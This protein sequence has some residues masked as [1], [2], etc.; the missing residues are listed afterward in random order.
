AKLGQHGHDRGAKV[1]AWGFGDL[2]FE[3]VVGPLFQA[4]VEAADLAVALKVQVVG[5]SSLGAGH[6]TL[7][8]ALVAALRERGAE[9]VV[10]VV[11]GVIPR[12]DYDFLLEH[13]VAA[14]F[15]PGT[16]VLDAAS[17]VLDIVEGRRRNR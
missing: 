15:G 16:N 8:R 9:N 10:V 2:C 14:V 7:A 12:Q 11:G 1:S 4:P 13:G 6:K 17:A 5:V 3:V